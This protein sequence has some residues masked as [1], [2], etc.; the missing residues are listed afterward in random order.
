MVKSS[1]VNQKNFKAFVLLAFLQE[2]FF[3]DEESILENWD[4]KGGSEFSR[5]ALSGN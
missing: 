3:G 4:K 1:G 5:S 2:K